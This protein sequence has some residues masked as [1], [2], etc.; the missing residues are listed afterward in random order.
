MLYEVITIALR[1]WNKTRHIN[2]VADMQARQHAVL[3]AMGKE[4]ADLLIQDVITSYSIHYTKL[5][6]ICRVDHTPATDPKY[7][8]HLES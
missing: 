1:S 2:A 3:V 6:D 4:Q 5:Y 8:T 7:V